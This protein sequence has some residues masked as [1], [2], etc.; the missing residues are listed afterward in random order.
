MDSS[1]IAPQ[2]QR[3]KQYLQKSHFSGSI[4]DLLR[5]TEIARRGQSSMHKPHAT[6]RVLSIFIPT[7]PSTNPS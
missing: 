4:A 3:F 1:E 2:M 5:L 6:P 7:Q